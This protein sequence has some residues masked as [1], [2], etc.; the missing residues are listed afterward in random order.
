MYLIK[1]KLLLWLMR[2]LALVLLRSTL[3]I[4][5]VSRRTKWPF[6]C[7]FL[8]RSCL[9]VTLLLLILITPIVI[10]PPTLW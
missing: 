7:Q 5:E 8:L 4:S 3:D 2:I 9:V 6:G 1:A 10:L